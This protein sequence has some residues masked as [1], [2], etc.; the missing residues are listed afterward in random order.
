MPGRGKCRRQIDRESASSPTRAPLT[1]IAPT[2]ALAAAMVDPDADPPR[3]A[4]GG[5]AE[6]GQRRDHPSF[7]GMDEAPHVAAPALEVQ[8]HI[9]DALAGAVIGVAPAAA[10][11]VDREPLGLNSSAGSALVPAV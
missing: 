5:D 2:L 11:R 3:R 7:E 8:Q 4:A 10:G 1:P 6:L 9:D